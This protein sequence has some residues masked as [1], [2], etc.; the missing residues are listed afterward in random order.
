MVPRLHRDFPPE[1][2]V[3]NSRLPYLHKNREFQRSCLEYQLEP[4]GRELSIRCSKGGRCTL[5]SRTMSIGVPAEAAA[6]RAW[7]YAFCATL[8]VQY[9]IFRVQPSTFHVRVDGSR[10]QL[11]KPTA[12]DPIVD[13]AS[14]TPANHRPVYEAIC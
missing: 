13:A 9:P 12:H 2:A 6:N 5:W 14:S 8:T 1:C 10:V 4:A 11:P 3:R 7:T